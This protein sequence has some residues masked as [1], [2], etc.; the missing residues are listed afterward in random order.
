MIGLRGEIGLTLPDETAGHKNM[1]Q[2]IQLRWIAV[3]GQV[4]TIIGTEWLFH[5]ALP[6]ATMGLVLA[7]LVTLNVVSLARLRLPAPVRNGELLAALLFDVLALTAQLYL[8]GGATNPFISLYL[9][10]VT[11]S[12][13]LLAA[14]STWAVVGVAGA[15]FG[16]LTLVYQPLRLPPWLGSDLFQ[17][18]I[19]GMFAC[20]ILDAALIV[21]FMNRIS[22]NLRGRDAR[23]A[24]LRQQAA[25]EGHILRMG[26]LASGAAHELG[27]PLATLAVIL[28]DWRRLPALAADPE[29]RQELEDM[30]AEV[31]RCKAIVTGI[32]M[33]AGEARGEGADVTTV[34]AFLDE[35]VEDWRGKRLVRQLVYERGFADDVL[36]VA[37]SALKQVIFNVLDNAAEASPEWVAL[38]TAREGDSLVIL[39]ADHGPGFRPEVLENLGKPYQSTK[40]KRGG[41]LGLFL[42]VNVLRKLGGQVTAGNTPAGAEVR[43][44]LPLAALTI[45]S[46][47][48]AA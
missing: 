28:N 30:E 45:E 23:L 25:E 42:V 21:V 17:L 46:P 1:L 12:A 18:H 31:Q 10:Q 9:L 15:A 39:V 27:T 44:T 5:I 16:L 14:W 41:G 35:V 22:A 7:F 24:D 2:L 40:G 26:L 34:K 13:V 33:S 11:I 29:L 47:A 43:L 4:L 8:S 48:D 37:D 3:V 38:T 20:F 19:L 32:L 36:I 6:L